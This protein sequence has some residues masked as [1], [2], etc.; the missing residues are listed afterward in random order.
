MSPEVIAVCRMQCVFFFSLSYNEDC[1]L[2]NCTVE[3][4]K[5]TLKLFHHK[6]L[7]KTWR[8]CVYFPNMKANF[9]IGTVYLLRIVPILIFQIATPTIDRI[10]KLVETTHKYTC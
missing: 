1:Y 5:K 7:A 4:K 2:L 6:V 9:K 10:F 3:K 8:D